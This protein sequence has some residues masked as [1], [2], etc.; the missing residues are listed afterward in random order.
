M[1]IKYEVILKHEEISLLN[2]FLSRGKHSASKSKR[3]LAL[4]LVRE[5]NKTDAEI[6]KIVRMHRRSIEEL[7]KRFIGEGFETCLDSKPRG[8]RQ[9][10][11]TGEDE[12]HL[13]VL[14][15]E[16]RE[17]GTTHR[18]LRELSDRFVTP[19]ERKVSYETIRRTLKRP[20]L[21]PWQKKE[22]CIPPDSNAEFVA[23]M[24]DILEL[25]KKEP[26]PMRPPVCM[27]ECPR[28]LIGET[29][30]PVPGKPGSVRKY[31]TEY[32]RNGTADIF[33]FLAPHTGW[34]HAEVLEHRTMKDWAGQIRK[35]V[36]LDF[37][38][39]E[40]VVLVCDNL[41]THRPA[42]LYET[43]P[44]QEARIILDRLEIHYTPKHGSWL[45][46]AEIELSVINNHGLPE[47]VPTV[48]QMKCEV[49]AWE[50]KRND[51]VKKIVWRFTTQDPN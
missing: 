49:A 3:A 13:I 12:A 22:W 25:Y 9:S 28:Q 30:T 20:E 43:F 33:M 5:Q 47:R 32:V 10:V 51:S 36:D 21:K 7:R 44:P 35:L 2:E 42:A 14:A 27:D 40:K 38:H 16:E 39:A 18:T 23:C 26:D 4:L 34:R 29:R 31:D 11:I 6:V 19:E 24:E 1:K 17:K 15:C 48:E 50:K 46:M 8:H 41:N 45:N 37:P